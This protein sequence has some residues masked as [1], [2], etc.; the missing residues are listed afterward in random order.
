MKKLKKKLAKFL[1]K[2]NLSNYN[3][4]E[5]VISDF[6]SKISKSER[7]ISSLKSQQRSYQ[8]IQSQEDSE[9][10]ND[11]LPHAIHREEVELNFLN[12]VLKQVKK[13]QHNFSSAAGNYR[14]FEENYNNQE[15]ELHG[16]AHEEEAVKL[17]NQLISELKK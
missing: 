7:E 1:A 3:K 13:I 6:E 12:L 2:I 4:L 15:A 5:K 8:N 16:K 9:M 17:L 11:E 10:F 14:Q